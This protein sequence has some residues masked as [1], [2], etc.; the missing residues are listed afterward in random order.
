MKVYLIAY[1]GKISQEGYSKFED[2]QKYCAERGRR[3]NQWVWVDENMYMY[4]IIE[5]KIV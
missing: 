2:A 4:K 1:D 3:M 5:V